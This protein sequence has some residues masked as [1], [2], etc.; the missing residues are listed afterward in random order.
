MQREYATALRAGFRRAIMLAAGALACAAPLAQGAGAEWRP[1]KN[2]EIVA[3]AGPGGGYDRMARAIQRIWQARK[4]VDATITVVNKPGGGGAIGWTY[5]NQHAGD[6]HYLSTVSPPLL[7]NYIT[8]GSPLSFNDVTPLA[9]LGTEYVVLTVR[10][11]SPIK[12]GGDLVARLKKDPASV[13]VGLSPGLGTHSHIGLALAMKAVG[14]DARKVRT[15][16][17]AAGSEAATAL[18]G[19]HVELVS[20]TAG[21]VLP[22]I[23]A[24]KLR[25][26][27]VTAPQRVGGGLAEVPT[28]KEQGVAAVFSNWRG[29]I[30]PRGLSAAQI[31]YWDDVFAKLSQTG[32]WK[33]DLENNSLEAVYLN[34]RETRKFLGA[35]HAQ[36]KALLSELGMAK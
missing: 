10:A 34:S 28:W 7:T 12:S 20:S 36:L 26:I 11:D 2:I 22:H 33:K 19:G 15:V 30:G 8:G 17:F 29:L 23:R 35:E 5:L 13:A 9:V 27:A 31:A 1:E 32:E 24:G 25:A 4:L 18:L 21:N 16:V 14:V 3:A 6:G